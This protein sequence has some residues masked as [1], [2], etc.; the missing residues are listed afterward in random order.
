MLAATSCLFTNT[1]DEH[2]LIGR[3]TD[4]PSVWFAAGFSGH[5][6][7]FCSVVG[8]VLADLALDGGTDKDIGLFDPSRLMRRLGG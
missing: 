3:L 7:K 8:E 6:Y 1:S 2:F 4:A 5:G